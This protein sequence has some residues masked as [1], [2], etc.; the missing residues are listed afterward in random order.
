MF[1]I[2]R[3]LD[4]QTDRQINGQRQTKMTERQCCETKRDDKA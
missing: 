2:G 1:K 4:K 3:K